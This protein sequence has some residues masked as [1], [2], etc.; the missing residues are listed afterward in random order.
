L[1][2]LARLI[3]DNTVMEEGQCSHFALLGC[4]RLH[5]NGLFA[6]INAEHHPIGTRHQH[7][8]DVLGAVNV[9]TL[10]AL[11]LAK[12]KRLQPVTTGLSPSLNV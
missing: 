6:V 11:A 3:F 1:T 4:K 12:E 9:P 2:E 7:I 10:A 8:K 5:Y